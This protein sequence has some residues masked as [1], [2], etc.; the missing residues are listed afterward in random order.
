MRTGKASQGRTL[1]GRRKTPTCARRPNSLLSAAGIAGALVIIVV[2]ARPTLTPRAAARQGSETPTQEIVANLA[3]GRVV[4]AVVKDAILIGTAENPIEA[5][6][7]PPTPVQLTSVRA[8]VILG[9]VDWFSPSSQQD[10]ARLDAELPHL[11]SRLAAEAPRLAGTPGG[12]EASDIEATGQGLLERLNALAKSLHGKVEMPAGEAL[13][14]LI[15]ADYLPGYGPEVW[16]LRYEMKQVEERRDYWN[17]RVL[18]PTYLQFW[19]PEKG[20]PRTLVEFDYPA[21]SGHPTLLELLRQND[22]RLAK[23]RSSGATMEQVAALF[24]EGQSIK[25]PVADAAQFLRAVLDATARP[26]ARETMAVIRQESGFQWVLPPPAEAE[27]PARQQA[28][29][30]AEQEKRPPEAPSLLKPPS[31]R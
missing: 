7:R 23:I 8:G 3:A 20:Q 6:T 26:Q 19:P 31:S 2:L 18:R 28:H 4:I 29:E 21:E 16:Q 17:T 11:R 15:I 14:E 22:P 27:K 30:P 10:L 1:L 24:L 5:E 12:G 25:A 9:S 13:A